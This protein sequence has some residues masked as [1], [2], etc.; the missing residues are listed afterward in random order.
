MSPQHHLT[1]GLSGTPIPAPLPSQQNDEIEYLEL[2]HDM[3]EEARQAPPRPPRPSSPSVEY[4]DLDPD[5]TQAPRFVTEKREEEKDGS[6]SG[7]STL[8]RRDV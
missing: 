4:I 2:S 3:E 8:T 5:K 6:M 7:R 1:E